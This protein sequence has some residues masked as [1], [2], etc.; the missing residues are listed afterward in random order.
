DQ[1][2]APPELEP[3]MKRLI[4][5]LAAGCALVALTTGAHAAKDDV[6]LVSQNSAGVKADQASFRPALSANGRFVAFESIAANLD[7]SDANGVD[8]IYVRDLQTGTTKLVSRASGAAG[9]KPDGNSFGPSISSDG[10]FVAF[11]SLATDLDPADPNA[12]ADVYVRDL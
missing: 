7:G 8:Y 1:R 10:R 9:V 5:I 6:D 11:M 2:S 3:L 4:W 12:N